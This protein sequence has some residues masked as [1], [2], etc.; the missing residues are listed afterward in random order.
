MDKIAKDAKKKYLLYDKKIKIGRL[1]KVL[2]MKPVLCHQFQIIIF[3]NEDKY[4][5]F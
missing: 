3:I 1:P 4:M 5:T 2:F